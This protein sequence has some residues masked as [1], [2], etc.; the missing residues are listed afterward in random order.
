MTDTAPAKKDVVPSA[1]RDKY[2]ATGGTNGDFIATGLQKIGKDG[3]ESLHA[4]ASENGIDH[5]KWSHMNPGMQRMNL[6]NVLRGTYLKGGSIKM[7][8]KEYNAKHQAED[9][10]GKIEDNDK[11]MAALASYLDLND[12]PRTVASLRKVFF[13]ESA[14]DKAKKKADAKAARE[15][16]KAKGKDLKAAKA[17]EKK[18]KA[19]LDKGIVAV[20]KA[21]KAVED[22]KTDAK[23]KADAVKAAG[24]DEAKKKAA[25]GALSKANEKVGKLEDKADDLRKKNDG[26]KATHDAAVAKVAELSA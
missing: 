25:E 14:E 7:L 12:S 15:A 3:I 16:D 5:K 19:A 21:D 9:F 8:G 18:A 17:D 23:A 22:A 10:T 24:D 20:E 2:K 13:E 6:A 1:Y 26:L 4:V 11:S